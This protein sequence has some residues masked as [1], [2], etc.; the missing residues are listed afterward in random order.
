MIINNTIRVKNIGVRV[1]RGSKSVYTTRVPRLLECT[2][3]D[4]SYEVDFSF[5]EHFTEKLTRLLGSVGIKEIEVGHGMGISASDQVVQARCSDK[6]YALAA[7]RGIISNSKWGMFGVSGI[8]KKDDIKSIL[9]L[10]M[11]FFRFGCDIP[12]FRESLEFLEDI[13][14]KIP[15]YI[16][17]MRSHEL[18]PTI[19]KQLLTMLSNTNFQGIYLVDSAG[20]MLP[21]DLLP[22][23]DVLLE[24]RGTLE[25][26][27]H[28]HDNLGMANANSLLLAE[29]GFDLLDATLQGIGRS[30]GNASLEQLAAIFD[31]EGFTKA[32][33]LVEILKIGEQEVIPQ[34]TR[35]G[36]S[37]LD[38]YAGYTRFHTSL[39]EKLHEY[40]SQN[41]LDL[42]T[43]M[44]EFSK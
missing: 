32:Y 23:C 28:G 5:D 41:A 40:A 31:R 14:H 6:E 25:L 22:L 7:Q 9:D 1:Y 11:G 33:S 42:Y 17:L 12:S 15:V 35:S 44:R 21:K 20:C 18:T 36:Y 27:F 39:Y 29:N 43:A 8:C 19:L 37:G 4:G 34:I 2:L 30:T 3:R 38:T 13:T 16:N 26:G 10:G 24:N